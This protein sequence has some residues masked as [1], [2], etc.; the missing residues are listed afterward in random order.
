[1]L[2]GAS[3]RLNSSR[4]KAVAAALATSSLRICYSSVLHGLRHLRR[5]ETHARHPLHAWLTCYIPKCDTSPPLD[6]PWVHSYD[7]KEWPGEY[8]VEKILGHRKKKGGGL[9]LL[10]RWKPI[11]GQTFDDSWEHEGRTHF[12]RVSYVFLC[13]LLS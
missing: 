12:S 9:E 6:R 10:I 7:A 13:I 1:M 4:P 5:P 3:K 2:P 11:D 8:K